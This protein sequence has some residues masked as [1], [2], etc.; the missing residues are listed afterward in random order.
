MG[1]EDSNIYI[2]SAVSSVLVSSC[3]NC[4]IFVAAVTKTATI[5][6]CEGS[7][8]IVAANQLRIGNCIDSLVHCY[9]PQYPPIVYG[10]TRNL[11]LAPHNVMY[12]HFLGHLERAQV[13][14]EVPGEKNSEWFAKATNNFKAPVILGKT[15]NNYGGSPSK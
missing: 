4:T 3:V 13:K 14:F 8:L 2:D 10:D 6:K 9:V 7:T 15:E 11:R 5:E 1:C 12:S